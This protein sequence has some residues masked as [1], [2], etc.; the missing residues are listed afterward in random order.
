MVALPDLY[1]QT[2]IESFQYAE[3]AFLPSHIHY[4]GLLL[5]PPSQHPLPDWWHELD[6]TKRLVLVTQGTIANRDLGQLIGPAWT[7]LA[8]QED[9]IV[10]VTTA[11]Q[12]IESILT[13]IPANAHVT[14][15]L[16]YEL[17]MS[18]VALPIA[19]GGYGTV[20]LALAHGIGIVLA[21]MTEDKEEVSAHVQWAGVRIDLRT[22]QATA[23]SLRTAAREV[24]ET[25]CIVSGQSS[26]H[27]SL[28]A[29][30]QRWKC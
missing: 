7:G 10:L 2:G 29:T 4:V 22:N 3:D 19:N 9:T 28:P 20:S 14:S 17:I 23:E 12:P 11:G 21:G 6:K 15:F 26:L 24:L 18:N 25:W 13:E 30:T 1:L 16:P 8:A 27:R 5:L